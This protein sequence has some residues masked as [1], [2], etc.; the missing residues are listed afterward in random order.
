MKL[1]IP[2]RRCWCLTDIQT[3]IFSF[4]ELSLCTTGHKENES[5]IFAQVLVHLEHK[6]SDFRSLCSNF[7]TV[8]SVPWVFV[9]AWA[10]AWWS[11][12]A[13]ARSGLVFT[14]ESADEE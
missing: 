12:P 13:L 2:L 10:A 11:N 9:L 6:R 1:R 3:D 5:K 14:S 8:R 7:A 4:S